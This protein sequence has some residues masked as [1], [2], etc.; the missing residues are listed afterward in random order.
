MGECLYK[1][2]G[3]TKDILMVISPALINNNINRLKSLDISE[4]VGISISSESAVG[5][6]VRS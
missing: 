6:Q 2:C 3:Y 4:C 1:L 5:V